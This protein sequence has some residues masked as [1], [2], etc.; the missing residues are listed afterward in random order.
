MPTP[1]RKILLVDDD[2]RLRALL[3]RYLDEHGF[4]VKAVADASAMDRALLRER[5]DEG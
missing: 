2:A 3:T 1:A 5:F 4:Y